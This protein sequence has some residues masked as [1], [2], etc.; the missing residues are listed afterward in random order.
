MFNEILRSNT[1]ESLNRDIDFLVLSCAAYRITTLTITDMMLLDSVTN[2]DYVLANKIEEHF[3]SK[4]LISELKGIVFGKFKQDL[5]QFLFSKRTEVSLD[6]LPM[7]ASLPK[8]YHE[9]ISVESITEKL[10]KTTKITR[11]Q[12]VISV[13]IDFVGKVQK[14]H[15]NKN[16]NEYWFK[17][18][19]ND[20]YMIE[21]EGKNSLLN[22]WDFLIS[23]KTLKVS[24]A[25]KF[26]NSDFQFHKFIDFQVVNV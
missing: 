14:F 23:K 20:P 6:N 12:R 8:L 13:D 19:N 15:K 21:I 18:V 2:E 22:T 17:D 10:N 16:Y 4:L 11:N 3:K 7:V 1:V 24:G 26:L 5:K 9:D 25:T